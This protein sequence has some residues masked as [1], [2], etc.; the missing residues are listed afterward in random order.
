MPEDR[1]AGCRP[2]PT[3]TLVPLVSDGGL[4]F[5]VALVALSVSFV[6]V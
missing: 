3:C 2:R 4:V 5:L 1:Q 6:R